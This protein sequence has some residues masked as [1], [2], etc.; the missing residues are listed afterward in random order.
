MFFSF[1]LPPPKAAANGLRGRPKRGAEG[2]TPPKGEGNP[3]EGGYFASMIY[4]YK[5]TL[6]NY[7]VNWN[8]EQFS[9]LFFLVDERI[10]D[11]IIGIYDVLHLRL[12][13]IYI[14]IYLMVVG[15]SSFRIK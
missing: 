8:V 13:S 6:K 4:V 7:S 15:T 2:T 9:V 5:G 11:P 3:A 12:L 1:L 14:Q 10:A